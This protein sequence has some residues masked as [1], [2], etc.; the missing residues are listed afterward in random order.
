M[1]VLSLPDDCLQEREEKKRGEQLL[2]DSTCV[3]SQEL[4]KT[5][6]NGAMGRVDGA[7]GSCV[8]DLIS[9]ASLRV[10]LPPPCS[11]SSSC[12]CSPL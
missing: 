4:M 1:S 5:K 9:K 3:I 12:L 11:P 6:L 7:G 10:I 2:S 8:L